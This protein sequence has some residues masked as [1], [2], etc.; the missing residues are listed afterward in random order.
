MYLQRVSI[1]GLLISLSF[2]LNVQVVQAA[3][4]K[5]VKGKRVL[6]E[7]QTDE[8]KKNEIYYVIRDG[9]RVG[10]IKI[11]A[12]KGSKAL[13]QLGKGQASQG[14]QLVLRGAKAASPS[15]AAAAES[16]TDDSGATGVRLLKQN[17]YWGIVGGLSQSSATVDLRNAAGA[18]LGTVD[19]SGMGFNLKGLFDYPMFSAVWFRAMGGVEQFVAG[20]TNNNNCGTECTIDITYLTADFW[21]RLVFGSNH[22]W[23]AGAGFDL[24]FP[25][26]KSS[27]ALDE[28]S[29]TNT[30]ILGVGGGVDFILKSG[31]YIP[32]Q[33]EYGMY[34][35]S[36]QVK[37]SAIMIRAGYATRF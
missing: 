25:L 32:V 18:S 8:V 4:V 24:L 20:G 26:S 3:T 17:G 30:S 13:A 6:I 31:A 7:V 2:F 16:A 28:S 29:I 12:I 10:I 21:G 14:D 23:W 35:E 19:L 1:F 5:A 27:T 34:P 9:K 33:I 11:R 37:A 36:D 22:R 15:Q